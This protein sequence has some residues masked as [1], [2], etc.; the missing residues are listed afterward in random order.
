MDDDAGDDIRFINKTNRLT[1]DQNKGIF[2][3]PATIPAETTDADTNNAETTNAETTDADT[4]T[5]A[6]TTNAD[7]V[8]TTTIPVDTTTD[9][10]V[11][12]SE[13]MIGEYKVTKADELKPKIGNA[14]D[15]YRVTKGEDEYFVFKGLVNSPMTGGK[16]KSKSQKRGGKK[17]KQTKKQRGGSRHRRSNRRR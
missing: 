16:K 17:Q 4:T 8:D 5:N 7:A 11:D 6:D 14:T 10:V 15:A 9:G 3:N 13:Q 1:K 2:S 12:S